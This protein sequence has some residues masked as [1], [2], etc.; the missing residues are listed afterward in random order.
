MIQFEWTVNCFRQLFKL[1][2]QDVKD[3]ITTV[4]STVSLSS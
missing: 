2:Y 4:E 3:K 1:F